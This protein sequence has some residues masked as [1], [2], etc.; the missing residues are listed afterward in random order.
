MKKIYQ[1]FVKAY[2]LWY[3]L[4]LFRKLFWCYTRSGMDANTA[5]RN[6]CNAFEFIAGFEYST[7]YE[8][9]S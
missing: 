2:R 8:R 7:I 1:K 9:Y 5:L 3:Y 6:A 4:R